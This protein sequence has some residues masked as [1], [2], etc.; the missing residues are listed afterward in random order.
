[1]G[2]KGQ[3][4]RRGCPFFESRGGNW[5]S[6]SPTK[7]LPEHITIRQGGRELVAEGVVIIALDHRSG[8]V[9]ELNHIAVGV[10]LVVALGG[11]VDAPR[12][13]Q[14]PDVLLHRGAGD[15]QHQLVA[16]PH[17]TNNTL[18]FRKQGVVS[19]CK[20]KGCAYHI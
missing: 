3:P 5:D 7:G 18:F 1:M 14:T 13:G 10:V 6:L 17:R 15:L 8:G 9:G 4:P 11:S 19:L 2:K 16:V 12:Q 20:I